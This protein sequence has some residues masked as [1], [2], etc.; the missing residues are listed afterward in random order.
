MQSK[1]QQGNAGLVRNNHTCIIALC[2]LL[3]T[4]KLGPRTIDLRSFGSINPYCLSGD[5]MSSL[6]MVH[7]SESEDDRRARNSGPSSRLSMPAWSPGCHCCNGANAVCDILSSFAHAF[8]MHL[9]HSDWR[10]TSHH[11][12]HRLMPPRP[13]EFRPSRRLR[14]RAGVSNYGYFAAAVVEQY[15]THC[16]WNCTGGPWIA[17]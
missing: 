16:L 6:A 12:A 9:R 1:Y 15:I 2:P 8:I 10:T 7:S 17:M 3:F 4:S 5:P 11:I 14:P 13:L